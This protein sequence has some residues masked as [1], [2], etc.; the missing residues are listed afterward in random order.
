[1]HDLPFLK[2]FTYSILGYLYWFTYYTTTHRFLGIRISSLVKMLAIVL[3]LATWFG[4]WGEPMLI[5]SLLLLA[6]VFAVYWIAKRVGYFSFVPSPYRI[7]FDEEESELT[8]YERIAIGATGIFSLQ[9]WELSVLLRPAQ[10]WQVPRGDHAVMVAHEPQKYLYQF[11]NVADVQAV[12]NGWLLFGRHPQKALA[13]SFLSIWG[14]EFSQLQVNIFG[15]ITQTAQPANRTIYLSF[16]DAES[17]QA[18]CRNILVD[19]RRYKSGDR[20]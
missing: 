15:S 19:M 8:P 13:I 1:M 17:E 4:D 10:Y 11:F 3:V 12:R 14:P 16:P 7:D 20:V 5:L 6:G 9:E 2:R 18:V